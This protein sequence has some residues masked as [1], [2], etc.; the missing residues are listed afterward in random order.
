M[1]FKIFLGT[2]N[3]RSGGSDIL[4]LTPHLVF[5]TRSSN[6]RR[7]DGFRQ[8]LRISANYIIRP[9]L[10]RLYVFNHGKEAVSVVNASAYAVGC[11]WA[12]ELPPRP[13]GVNVSGMLGCGGHWR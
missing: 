2:A 1:L 9:T 6:S 5:I 10:L 7:Y 8:W 4:V 3:V 13:S 11:G 12:V